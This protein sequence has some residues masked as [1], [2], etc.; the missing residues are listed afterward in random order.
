MLLVEHDPRRLTKVV[1][2]DQRG[3]EVLWFNVGISLFGWFIK[4][5]NKK[6][7]RSPYGERVKFQVVTRLS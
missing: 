4:A 1:Q 7:T 5:L 2:S 3:V 6:K